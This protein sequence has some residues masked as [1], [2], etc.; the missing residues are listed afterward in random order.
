[1][2]CLVCLGKNVELLIFSV[3]NVR[4]SPR[5]SS[6]CRG[7]ICKSRH[8][9]YKASFSAAD[10]YQSFIPHLHQLKAN[11]LTVNLPDRYLSGVI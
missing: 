6:N 4:L 1:M 3:E 11:P 10:N 7:I 5:F 8:F 9:S 2:G